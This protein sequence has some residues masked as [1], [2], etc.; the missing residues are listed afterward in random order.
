EREWQKDHPWHQYVAG[1]NW[2]YFNGMGFPTLIE[3]IEKVD[4]MTVRF[5]LKRPEAPFLANVAMPF[6]SIMSKEYADKLEA[7]GNMQMLNQQ[8]LASGAFVFVA[9]QGD[10][11]FGYRA[12]EDYRTGRQMIEDLVCGI[13]PDA[14]VRCQKLQAGEC[15]LMLYPNAADVESMKA[16]PTLK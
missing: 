9:L 10:A 14:S 2:E 5:T 1:A 4:D 11:V 7:D 13:T 16:D 12:H 8:P 3:S 15:Q 6:A